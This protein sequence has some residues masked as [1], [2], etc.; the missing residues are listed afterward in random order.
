MTGRHRRP[1]PRPD[2]RKLTAAAAGTVGATALVLPLTPGAAVAHSLHAVPKPPGHPPVLSGHSHQS[3]GDRVVHAASE[4][5][6]HPY[7]W[8][9]EGPVAFDCS[10]LTKYVYKQFG[11][12]L[13]HNAAAQYDVVRHVAKSDIRHGDLVFIYDEHGIFHVGIYAG[14]HRMWAATHTG[15]I[16]RKQEIWT[17]RYVVGRP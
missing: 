6:G 9:G 12:H 16:V 10:G 2:A 11:V 4:E 5:Y 1:R 15:D 17:D 3:R 8:G 13:P 14:G 7:M